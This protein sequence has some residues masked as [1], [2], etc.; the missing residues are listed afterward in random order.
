MVRTEDWLPVGSIVHVEGRR[1]LLMVTA[2]MVGDER[3]GVLWDYA[4]VPYPQGLTGPNGD[5]MFNKDSVD[6]MFA[7]GYQSADGERM[8]QLLVQ[9][10]DSFEEG[11]LRAAS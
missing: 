2:A 10:Q 4:A 6:G 11:K 3:T 9:A 7:L 8:Q 5:V 1:G